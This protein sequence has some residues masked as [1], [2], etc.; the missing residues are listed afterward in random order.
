MQADDR[1]FTTV[2]TMTFPTAKQF[3]ADRTRAC[4]V[5]KHRLQ[6]AMFAAMIA[7]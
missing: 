5:G 6:A 4:L 1:G 7:R 3:E 2:L